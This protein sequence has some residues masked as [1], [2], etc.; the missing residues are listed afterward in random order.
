MLFQNL[1]ASAPGL[2]STVSVSP[3]STYDLVVSLYSGHDVP[4]ELS[5]V[6]FL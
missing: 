5:G 4:S 6:G 2:V 3:I 1:M